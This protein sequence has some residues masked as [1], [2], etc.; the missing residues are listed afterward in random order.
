MEEK[1]WWAYGRVLHELRTPI[2]R[3]LLQLQLGLEAFQPRREVQ[4]QLWQG[5]AAPAWVP[6]QG[7]PMGG[8]VVLPLRF[9]R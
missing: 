7:P 5:S 3:I 8:G 6:L 1:S 2:P 9:G 4:A